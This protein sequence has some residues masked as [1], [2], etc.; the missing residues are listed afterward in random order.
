MKLAFRRITGLPVVHSYGVPSNGRSS[1]RNVPPIGERLAFV[2]Q[3]RHDAYAVSEV[4]HRSVDLPPC[5]HPGEMPLVL[6]VSD[7]LASSV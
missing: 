6:N 3:G 4:I 7:A 5:R 2:N 1:D